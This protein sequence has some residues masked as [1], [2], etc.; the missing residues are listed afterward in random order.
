MRPLCKL[1][2]IGVLF[3]SFS[4]EA[5]TAEKL[6]L[7]DG[8]I[9]YNKDAWENYPP[10]KAIQILQ[11]AGIT[12]AF[13]SSTPDDGTLKLYAL[14]PKLVVPVLRPYRSYD[15]RNGWFQDQEV[16]QFLED[17]LRRN[18][19]KGIGEFHLY[20]EQAKTP[21]VQRMVS[22]AVERSI[23]LQAH[24]DADAVEFLF[25]TNPEVK[26]LWAH[27][28]MV[29]SPETIGKMLNKYDRLWAELSL[30]YFDIVTGDDINPEWQKLF[31]NFPDRF[32]V[33][34]DTWE[35]S[36]WNDVD[37]LARMAQ[38]WLAKL[39]PDIAQRIAYKNAE[40]LIGN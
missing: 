1:L 10:E 23:F 27:A 26:I 36:R 34:T 31:Q 39:P 11:Q 38:A 33:G 3:L 35:S 4:G 6:P 16:M 13:V 5:T 32:I 17:R 18:I 30:R 21:E 8:H 28:G 15:D 20:G 14:A 40:R 2:L 24:S 22:M 12:R 37:V 7:F 25:A 29:E 19:Y 9:H